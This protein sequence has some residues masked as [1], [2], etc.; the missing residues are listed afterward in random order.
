MR[1]PSLFRLPKHQR[2]HIEP[3]YY[4]PVKMEIKERT[5]RIK[6]AMKRKITEDYK[7]T[8]I[9]FKR[10]ARA[11]PVASMLQLLIALILGMMVVGWLEFGNRI[12]YFLFWLVIPTYLL[13]LFIKMKKLRRKNE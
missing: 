9:H 11:S 12:F 6:Q 5:E 8:Q 13:Y 10:K 3:R 7:P 2:F 4:D 1:F